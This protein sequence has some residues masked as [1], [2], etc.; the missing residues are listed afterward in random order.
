MPPLSG[1]CDVAHL[2]RP[3]CLATPHNTRNQLRLRAL[4]FGTCAW[5]RA[6]RFGMTLCDTAT[7]TRAI[8]QGH[9][10]HDSPDLLVGRVQSGTGDAAR[11]LRLFNAE[12]RGK[13]GVP[14]FPGSLNVGL[15]TPFDWFAP[16][17]ESRS[18][19]FGM[20]EY[21]GERDILLL[22]CV[23]ENLGGERAYLWTT[24]TA[25]RTDD[26]TSLVEI[27]AS[28]HLRS[29]YNLTDG[30]EVRIRLLDPGL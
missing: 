10:L 23:L 24:T 11:W 12:Y 20:D 14:I 2:V 15:A 6:S 21:G 27:I 29:T 7:G 13:M 25:A 9:L 4:A 8:N 18:I 19:W 3:L 5:R 17:I 30:D 22:R 26:D 1:I 16:Q 28:V